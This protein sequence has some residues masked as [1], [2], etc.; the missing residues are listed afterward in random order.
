MTSNRSATASARI[1]SRLGP[2]N[3]NLDAW[4]TQDDQKLYKSK[5]K[6]HLKNNTGVYR[7]T[8][9][10]NDDFLNVTFNSVVGTKKPQLRQ[11]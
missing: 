5:D 1:F 4:L 8:R 3:G 11:S 6:S 7:W 2:N 9:N 10:K